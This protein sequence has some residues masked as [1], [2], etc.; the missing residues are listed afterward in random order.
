[1]GVRGLIL[2]ASSPQPEPGTRVPV[3]ERE[4]PDP[5]WVAGDARRETVTK[6]AW[7]NYKTWARIYYIVTMWE[8]RWPGHIDLVEDRED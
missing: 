5:G 1:M 3:A 8:A 2:G 4:K 6:E 7:L